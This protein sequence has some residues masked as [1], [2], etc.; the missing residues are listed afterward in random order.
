MGVP[1][2]LFPYYGTEDKVQNLDRQS[3]RVDGGARGEFDGAGLVL[4]SGRHMVVSAR[5]A[6]PLVLNSHC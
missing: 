6:G 5:V 3:P 1:F 4:R 2:L